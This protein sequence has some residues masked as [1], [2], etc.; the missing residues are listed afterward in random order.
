MQA[1]DAPRND[2]VTWPRPAARRIFLAAPLG[3]RSRTVVT[4]GE[5]APDF[6]LEA[7]DGTTV[8]L[9]DL[10]GRTV[11]LF[12]YPKDDTPG[13]TREACSFRDAFAD[14]A[15]RDAVVLGVSPDAVARHVRFRDKY[16][17]PFRLLADVDHAVAE[18]YGV[19]REKR[20]MGK[21][22]MGV[23]RTTFLIGPDGRIREVFENVRPE[24]HAEEIL[25]RL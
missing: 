13:C 22:Y 4:A 15:A 6:A 3:R 19:W 2:T 16:A 11:V 18:R 7:D 12:F 14:Y 25:E 20:F 24:G 10:R 21:K 17:L 8:R 1:N 23:A 5:A 9:A